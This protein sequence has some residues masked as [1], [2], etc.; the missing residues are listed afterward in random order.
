MIK[1]KKLHCIKESK[2]NKEFKEFQRLLWSN[3]KVNIHLS[4][5]TGK[6]NK[7]KAI[8]KELFIFKFSIT[9]E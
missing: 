7:V 2:G 1:L 5:I 9:D 4:G 8:S 6:E 3:M